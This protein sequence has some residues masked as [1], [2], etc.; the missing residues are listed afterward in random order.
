[1]A[2]IHSGRSAITTASTTALTRTS[3]ESPVPAT[4]STMAWACRPMSR[5]TAFSRTNWIVAQLRRS[6][7]RDWAVWKYI[8]LCPSSTPAVTTAS[9]PDACTSSAGR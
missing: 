6:A 9:T 7:M 5:K 2:K 4:R 8:D 1:M 3:R